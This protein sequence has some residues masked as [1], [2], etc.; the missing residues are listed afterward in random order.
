VHE[1][2]FVHDSNH[3]GNVA[4]AE[5]AAA[6]VNLGIPVLRPVAEHGRYDLAFELGNKLHR[7][8]C[9]WGGLDAGRSVVVVRIGGSW[10]SPNGYVK[11]TYAENEIDLLA[12]YC[13]ELDRCYLL[14]AHLVAG[15]RGIHLRLTPP[16]NAQR[17]SINLASDYEF[18]G[19]VAQWEE[20]R[21]GIPEAGGSSP[22]SS[23]SPD[24]TEVGVGAHE[25]REHFGYYMERAAAGEAIHITRRGKP[26]ARLGPPAPARG[27]STSPPEP[28]PRGILSRRL[29]K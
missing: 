16:L 24:S 26:H 4:E 20:R 29:M 7:V 15:L 18:A 2:V 1:H 8:Q 27:S 21:Y 6:A 22:P 14:P 28:C 13:G 19:A 11:S 12:V 10:L 17:A 5:I 3:K 23:T 25:F 9:K